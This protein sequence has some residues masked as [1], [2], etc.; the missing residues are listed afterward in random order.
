LPIIVFFYGGSWAGGSKAD[1]RFAGEALA[2]RGYIVAIPDYRVYPQV[3]YP[4]FL[5]DAAAAVAAVRPAVREQGIA[6]TGP[7]VVMGHS[8]GAHMAAMLALDDRWL[9]AQDMDPQRDLAAMVG[10]AGPYDFLPLRREQVK[11][12]F[13]PAADELEQTQPIHHA[14]PPHPPLILAAGQPDKIV[15]AENSISLHGA[16]QAAGGSSV[17]LLYE[18]LGHRLIVA[19][20]AWPLTL[21]TD[22][23]D[24]VDA[25]LGRTLPPVGDSPA[26]QG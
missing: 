1:Y 19:A 10:L 11:Q 15:V 22:V 23:L 2:A 24:D 12:V 9:A 7:L 5:E 6:A 21:F 3:R 13:A 17:L 25:A 16:V 26:P 8:S 14:A 20:L 4:V 18:S